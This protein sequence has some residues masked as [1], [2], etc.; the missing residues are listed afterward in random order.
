MGSGGPQRL[1]RVLCILSVLAGHLPPATAQWFYPLGMEDTTPDPSVSPT[2][3]SAPALD[4]EEGRHGGMG[5]Q[6]PRHPQL[7][8]PRQEEAPPECW[9]AGDTAVATTNAGNWECCATTVPLQLCR[10]APH[11]PFA[12]ADAGGVEPPRKVL[13][14]KPPLAMAPRGR[15][16]LA[17]GA[18]K[19][20][21][22]ALP[23][24]RGQVLFP[25]Q[26]LPDSPSP[27]ETPQP[28]SGPSLPPS[29]HLCPAPTS[30]LRLSRLCLLGKEPQQLLVSPDMVQPH[31]SAGAQL[32]LR[33]VGCRGAP[34]PSGYPHIP[35]LSAPR[36]SQQ[37]RPTAAPEIFE[38]SAEEEEFL[39][40]QVVEGTWSPGGLQGAAWD[41]SP[42]E[43]CWGTWAGRAGWGQCCRGRGRCSGVSLNLFSA[44]TTAKGLPQ[45]V[46]LAPE[47]DPAL[48]VRWAQ[49]A[50]AGPC[51]WGSCPPP[52]HP[53]PL[54]M[55][56]GS[57]CVCPVRPGPPGPKVRCVSSPPGKRLRDPLGQIP[58]LFW[59]FKTF[60]ALDLDS[61][62]WV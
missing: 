62:F 30:E 1:L 52:H 46:L 51:S 43:G 9:G 12:P 26:R 56:N 23:R 41:R 33:A 17:R 25:R 37:H 21:G 27:P 45:R 20:W 50:H 29:P 18:A 15:Q 3:P 34:Y 53:L 10:L 14:S 8:H 58:W 35:T 48:Q 49:G 42:G 5:A 28:L 11:R 44:Q 47:T 59:P 54:Q 55:H 36:P 57:S 38:G 31:G 16:S 7:L 19:G 4:G 32:P 13:L 2:A 40:I 24:T 22:H 6:L 39:Q 61:G 60:S